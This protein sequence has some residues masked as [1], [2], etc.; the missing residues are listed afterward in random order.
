MGIDYAGELRRIASELDT[1]FPAGKPGSAVVL[2]EA[3]DLI[4]RADDGEPS[5]ADEV[6]AVVTM[7][8]EWAADHGDEAVFFRCRQRLRAAWL[9][10]KGGA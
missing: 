10:S 8:D 3:A 9:K 4:D 1:P 2:R 7:L 5:L 6:Q